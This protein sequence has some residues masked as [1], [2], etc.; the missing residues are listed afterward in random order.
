MQQS[1]VGFLFEYST[2]KIKIQM[3]AHR[4]ILSHDS[5]IFH[6]EKKLRIFFPYFVYF[7]VVDEKSRLTNILSFC[8]VCIFSILDLYWI[9]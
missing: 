7:V 9:N 8:I 2:P 4:S 5:T 6:K 1:Y 3:F